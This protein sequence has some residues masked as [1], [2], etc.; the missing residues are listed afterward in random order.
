[1]TTTTL[2]DFTLLPDIVI[3]HADHRQ[4]TVL[5]LAGSEHSADVADALLHEL[6]RAMVVPDARIAHDVIR[7]G[8]SVRYRTSE[9]DERQVELVYP[10]N[11]DIAANRISVLTPIGAALIGLRKGQSITWTTRGGRKQVL[12]ILDVAPPAAADE[13]DPGPTAA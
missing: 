12:T 5:A 7:M 1:M 4:L 9:D 8:S 2:Q 3:G 11:A 6:D 13:D 10:A